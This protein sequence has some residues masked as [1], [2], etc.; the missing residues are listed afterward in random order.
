MVIADWQLQIGALVMGPTTG[1]TVTSIDGG[2]GKTDMRVGDTA[3]PLDHGSFYGRDWLGART[4]T[5]TVRVSG[6]GDPATASSR[7]DALLNEWQLVTP[8]TT[9]TKPLSV[10][11]AGRSTQRWKGRPRRAAVTE[12]SPS[13]YDVVC[14]Y[15]AADPRLYDDFLTTVTIGLPLVSGGLT[16]P[17]TF[18]IAFGDLGGGGTATLRN[19]GNFPT[20][21]TV[22]I[23]GPCISPELWNDTT[24]EAFKSTLTLGATDVMVV[25]FDQ[26]SVTFN[27]AERWSQTGDSVWWD[28]QP[29]GNSIRFLAHGP[30]AGAQASIQWRSAWIG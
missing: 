9:T 12:V 15:F 24:G 7:L 8:D 16:F 30:E 2:F 18:P 5:V 21:P 13:S 22:T 26:R 20:R 23:T 28:L 11:R 14:E 17:I 3:R 27:G 4:V 25:N 19:N 10:R 1:Y 29:G 6:D